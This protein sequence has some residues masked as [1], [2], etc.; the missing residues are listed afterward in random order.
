MRIDVGAV[1]F[2]DDDHGAQSALQGFAQYKTCLRHR[3]F[4]AVDD[5]N[6]AVDHTE[7]ALY[8]AAEV[9]VSGGVDDVD[10]MP[11]VAHGCVLG[12]NGDAAL[13]LQVVG[14]HDAVDDFLVFAE[15][16]RLT[17]EAVDECGFAVVDVGDDG[18]V[19]DMGDGWLF[20]RVTVA[21]LCEGFHN[22]A[23]H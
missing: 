18:H 19:A 5:E 16:A 3:A 9:G 11:F 22:C 23:C 7:N 4:A 2:V 17:Q 1:D 14:V 6:G 8:F 21:D 20:C 15:D 12:E 10:Q 13:A